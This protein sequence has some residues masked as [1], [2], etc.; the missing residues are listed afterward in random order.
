M[1]LPTGPIPKVAYGDII[2]ESWGDSVAQSLNNL[3]QLAD[4]VTWS[5]TTGEVHKAE[6]GGVMGV[7]FT[8]G[9]DTPK[10][11]LVPDWAQTALVTYSITGVQQ[12]PEGAGRVTYLLQGQV[13]PEEGRTVRL[14]GRGGWFGM[15]WAD[16][17]NVNPIEGDRTIRIKAQR[18][19]GTGTECWKFFDQSDIA[20][21]L[22]FSGAIRI[23]P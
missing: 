9:G 8:V 12:D 16:N 21:W 1:A 3:T 20:V 19:E 15:S 4:W 2:E 18:L 13:G 6:T 17:L 22:V 10:E 11:V 5:P 23:W 14:S 7:W